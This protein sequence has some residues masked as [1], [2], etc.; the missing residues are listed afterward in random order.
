MILQHSAP[1][2]QPLLPVEPR[3]VGDVCRYS[4]ECE[5]AHLLGAER[6]LMLTQG[7]DAHSGNLLLLLSYP[8][9]REMVG[10]AMKV[11]VQEIMSTREEQ[12]TLM[13]SEFPSQGKC[14]N[15]FAVLLQSAELCSLGT[16]Q[17]LRKWHGAASG[18]GQG[19]ALHQ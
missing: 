15:G 6:G 5:A 11:R 10:T 1:I 19:K 12:S 14:Q 4:K 9:S 16:Q 17:G 13:F 2:L 18:E 8:C 7:T 3:A